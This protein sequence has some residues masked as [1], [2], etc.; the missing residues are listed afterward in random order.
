MMMGSPIGEVVCIPDIIDALENQMAFHFEKTTISCPTMLFHDNKYEPG[1]G[2]VL[3][4]NIYLKIHVLSMDSC[5]L[6]CRGSY[7]KNP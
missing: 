2:I 1:L 7:R 4:W 3:C 5:M 6:L